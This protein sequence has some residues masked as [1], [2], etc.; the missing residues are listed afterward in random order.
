MTQSIAYALPAG[1]RS[2]LAEQA[3]ADV[4]ADER[5]ILSLLQKNGPGVVAML[6]RMLGQEQ[7]VLDVYQSVICQLTSRGPKHIGRNRG[8][9]FYRTAMNAA[10]ELIRKRKREAE[11]LDRV[12]ESRSRSVGTREP[13]SSLDH[14]R[15]VTEIRTAVLSLPNHLRDVVVLRDLAGL[16]YLTISHVLGIT[17]GTARVYRR[18]AIIRLGE[19]LSE[20][21]SR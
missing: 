15:V 11:R 16:N 18:Q 2:V 13:G 9:Y 8:A 3:S 14:I 1:L 20:E 10:I 12:A 21:E 5:W 4:A 19:M 17:A 7:D 6:W